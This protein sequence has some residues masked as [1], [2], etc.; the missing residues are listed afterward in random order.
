MRVLVVNCG[1]SSLKFLVAGIGAGTG[2][3]ILARGIVERIGGDSLLSFRKEGLPATR[4]D[5]RV[6]D[7]EEAVRRAFD[8]VDSEVVHLSAGREKGIRGIGHRIV[9]GGKRFTRTTLIDESVTDAIDALEELAPL[10]NPPGIAGIRAARAVA[11]RAVPMVAVFDTSF[12]SALPDRASVYAIPYELSTRHAIR[13]YGFHGISYQHILS[14]YCAL[15]GLPPGKATFVAFHLGNGCSAA[16]VLRGVSVDTSMGFTPLEG[17]VM[18]TRSGDLDPAVIGFLSRE[19][20]LSCDEVDS[21]LNGKSGLLGLSGTSRD[22]RDLLD[23]TEER[24]RVRLAVDVFC[25][26]ARKYLGGYLAAL[27]GADAVVFSGGIGENAPEVRARILADME[28]C[29]IRLD[30][31]RNRETKGVEMDVSSPD[32]RLRVFV[33]PADEELV[34]A[35]ETAECLRKRDAPPSP[36]RP[37]AKEDPR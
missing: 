21:L 34:I 6:A 13:R 17:L 15:T 33:I 23:R 20:G 24:P 22:M 9:H 4:A 27:G 16:A 29:G 1:S 11:G 18:G 2:H 28:W 19:E 37:D 12:H 26:R 36:G 30:D 8:W 32:S 7:H 3:S 14:R 31:A 10:H 5:A 25:Y 35:R